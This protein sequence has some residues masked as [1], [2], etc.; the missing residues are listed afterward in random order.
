MDIGRMRH[1]VKI[2]EKSRVQDPVT[3]EITNG[4][5]DL[6]TVWASIDSVDGKEF[7]SASAEQAKTTHKIGMYYRDDLT[8]TMRLESAGI[9]YEIKA[10]LP[11]NDRSELTA[12]CEVL[13]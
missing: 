6:A 10:L 1:P 9:T 5:A 3:G 11:N 13:T 7:I 12:M 8:P 2:Q 4:W